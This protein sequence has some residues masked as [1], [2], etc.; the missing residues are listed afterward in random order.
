M[1]SA[2]LTRIR[3][4]GVAAY[5]VITRDGRRILLDPFLNG[6]PA[7]PVKAEDFDQVDLIIVTHAAMDHLGDTDIIAR[8]TGALVICGGEV[9][10]I[11][12][13]RAFRLPRYG[14][15]PGVCGSR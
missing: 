5:E 1:N 15:R 13:R 2:S 7:S 12:G 10:P 4:L 9:R 6:N 14:S 11:S 8:R 3:F